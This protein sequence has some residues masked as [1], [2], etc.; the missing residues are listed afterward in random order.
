MSALLNSSEYKLGTDMEG[1]SSGSALHAFMLEPRIVFDGDLALT[2][3]TVSDSSTSDSD[4]STSANADTGSTTD[5]SATVS[6]DVAATDNSAPTIG[7][8]QNTIEGIGSLRELTDDYYSDLTSGIEDLVISSDGQYAYTVIYSS[9]SG[10]VNHAS[11]VSVFSVGEDG[12]LSLV[13]SLYSAD[14]NGVVNE[15]LNGASLITFSADESEVYVYSESD[16]S[17]VTFSRDSDSG[18]MTYQSAQNLSDLTGTGSVSDLQENNGHLYLTEDA[19]IYVLQAG[20]DHTFSVLATYTNNENGV[21]GLGSH[22]VM[23]FAKDGDMLFVGGSG[24]ESVMSV[25]TVNDDGTLNFSATVDGTQT[26]YIN[27]VTTTSDGSEVFAFQRGSDDS[28]QVIA[29]YRDEQGSYRIA[30]TYDVSDD[31]TSLMVSNDDSALFTFGTS[32]SAYS[33]NAD[34]SLTDATSVDSTA[35]SISSGVTGIA[36]SAESDRIVAV[37]SGSVSVFS[38]QIPDAD[39]VEGGDA[40][41]VLPSGLISDVELD[42]LDDYQGASLEIHRAESVE[43]DHYTFLSGNGLSLNEGHIESDGT[44]IATWEATTD[45]VT[46][47][48]T[49]SVSHS[50]AQQVLRQIAFENTSDNPD[51]DGASATLNVVIADGSGSEAR[52][53]VTLN[54]TDINDAPVVSATSVDTG[55]TAGDDYISLF[56][57][58]QIDTVETGQSIWKVFLTVAG[59]T[60]NDVLKVDGNVF[61]LAKTGS[62]VTSANGFQYQIMESEGVKTVVLFVLSSAEDAEQVIDSIQ[63]RNTSLDASGERSFALSVQELAVSDNATSAAGV[64]SVVNVSVQEENLSPG[65]IEGD[66]VLFTYEENSG[67]QAYLEHLTISD[68][69]MDARNNGLGNYAGAKLTLSLDSDDKGGSLVFSDHDGY[70]YHAGR[71]SKDGVVI[72][73]VQL[74]DSAMTITFTEAY[75]QIPT[76][77][78]VNQ[79]LDRV[80]YENSADALN[81][82]SHLTATL[83]DSY[84]QSSTPFVVTIDHVNI[85]DAPSFSLGELYE[86]GV[87][88]RVMST[89]DLTDISGV[90]T[91]LISDA[92]DRLFVADDSGNIAVY[93]VDT[94]SGAL[95]F[96]ALNPIETDTTSID[97]LVT[98]TS[99]SVLYV[100]QNQ[101][102]YSEITV[103][104]VDDQGGLN[105]EQVVALDSSSTGGQV[106]GTVA[107]ITLS[108][109]GSYLFFTSSRSM[110]ALAVDETTGSLS[111]SEL[112]TFNSPWL[113]PYIYKPTAL[114]ASGDYLF[115]TS[116]AFNPTLIAYQITDSGIHWVG[117]IRND[118]TDAD[119]NTFS[120]SRDVIDIEV[121]QDNQYLV[122]ATENSVSVS[123]FDAESHTFTGLSTTDIDN[124]Y[125]TALSDDGQILYVTT[126]N[127]EVLRYT[128]SDDGALTQLDSTALSSTDA[129]LSVTE[130]GN[131]F[132]GQQ[133][134]TLYQFEQPIV[135]VTLGESTQLVPDV[136]LFDPES[137]FA[138]SYSGITV[139]LARSDDA[140]SHDSFTLDSDQ[141][142]TIEDDIIQYQ[143]NTV[144]R[145]SAE[146]GTLSLSV[147]GDLTGEQLSQ[148]LQ[149]IRYSNSSLTEAT[150]LSFT[151]TAT[152]PDGAT[153]SQTVLL[154]VTEPIEP[155]LVHTADAVLRDAKADEAYAQRLPDTLVEDPA[156]LSLSWQ[157][158]GLPDGVL[159]DAENLTLSGTPTE[160]GEFTLAF[161][162]TNSGEEQAS[163]ELPLSVALSDADAT[164]QVQVSEAST[165]F[166]AGQPFHYTFS[167]DTVTDPQ[168]LALTWDVAGLPQGVSF[169]ADTLTLSGSVRQGGNYDLDFSVTNSLGLVST[170]RFTL[171]VE[172]SNLPVHQEIPERPLP[173]MI[174]QGQGHLFSQSETQFSSSVGTSSMSTSSASS[175]SAN[176]FSANLLSTSPSSAEMWSRAMTTGH[177]WSSGAWS[178]GTVNSLHDTSTLLDQLN[179]WLGELHQEHPA[180]ELFG[181][182][183][184]DGRVEFALPDNLAVSQAKVVEISLPGGVALPSGIS[185]DP[186][187]GGLLVDRGLLHQLGKVTLSVTIQESSGETRTIDVNLHES[188]PG[189]QASVPEISSGPEISVPEISIPEISSI[190]QQAQQ[191]GN[192]AIEMRSQALFSELMN[193]SMNRGPVD[194]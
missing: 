70:V 140:D 162:V 164:P 71:I 48:F 5:D 160:A 193:D 51:A 34:H 13:Q 63:Y 158:S 78:D 114:V 101:S 128:L 106:F 137:A 189:Q 56:S 146:N 110:Y 47:S 66:N 156:D 105:Q 172:A 60:D 143:G 129:T 194:A 190:E 192:R 41:A 178:S 96:L 175:S 83:T 54:L 2:V 64:T 81:E 92:G 109:D 167:G 115:V 23:S 16:N 45:G 125:D 176:P 55:Y 116:I 187:D 95:N 117:Y 22:N 27:S 185:Y 159:F 15:G 59:A 108:G 10:T 103:Y 112:Q 145:F 39:Y 142:F 182:G 153:G 94:A 32:V 135:S 53:E 181:S 75:K 152:D 180:V 85:N 79:I 113:E 3:D 155:P 14:Q 28:T 191:A 19:S 76:T 7:Y 50:T 33:I 148:L 43:G 18:K 100:V 154:N 65:V 130:Q 73:T 147:T 121:T 119:G 132:V 69:N 77:E 99:G 123:R 133:N 9:D 37:T 138:A 46:V 173:D 188:T 38:Y 141:D 61:S 74:S 31:V 25:F 131:V 118:S 24:S 157:V 144:A 8:E 122:V 166:D 17:I 169:D 90:T 87:L 163:F 104:S 49:A 89:Q 150:Q 67:D 170:F 177:A 124:I 165:G 186:D 29:M 120:L 6:P 44:D 136:S 93:Q 80:H 62:P 98:N 183:S 12:N 58:V 126:G 11:V 86:Q 68:T 84:G 21:E 184:S 168:S 1:F 179:D 149:N 30:G 127:Q 102:S 174:F 36:W 88:S 35:A 111:L 151:L 4:A 97:T 82:Q 52:L 134:Y 139:T 26:Y 161:V 57:G 171:I 40:V 72:A 91:A 107:N 20:P 42:G